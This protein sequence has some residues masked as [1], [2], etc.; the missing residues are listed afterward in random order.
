MI[1]RDNYEEI[2]LLYA[3]NELS[4]AERQEVERFI[5]LHPE[6]REEWETI[7]QCRVS[8]DLHLA[9]PDRRG[10]LKPETENSNYT[11]DLL[12][13]ID[14]ELDEINT[15]RI[16]AALRQDPSV[17]NERSLLGQTVSQPDTTIVFPEKDRLYRKERERRIIPLPWLRTGAAA[18]IAGAI[19]LL[20]LLP[21][22]RPKPP[23][24]RIVARR[25]SPAISP[26]LF[27]L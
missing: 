22:K 11:D 16:E 27:Q 13:Y 26:N 9:F 3:D 4:A 24:A 10:L 14:G 23:A 7:L 6:L 20:L 18:A 19:A 1:T 21:A 17:A 12:S 15:I 25:D 2:F 8:P 5:D